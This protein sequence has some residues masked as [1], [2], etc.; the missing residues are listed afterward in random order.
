MGGRR[1]YWFSIKVGSEGGREEGRDP[2]SSYVLHTH[3]YEKRKGTP[4]NVDRERFHTTFFS[5]ERFYNTIIG[6]LQF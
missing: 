1:N 2:L 3:C 6:L 4:Y 5:P